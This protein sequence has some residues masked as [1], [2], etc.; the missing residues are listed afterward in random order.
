[1]K[2]QPLI[3]IGIPAYNRP[4]GL[5]RTLECL[6]RQTYRNIEIII[7]N[8]CSP[9][10]ETE[11]VAKEYIKRDSR[12]SY[13]H[14]EMNMG[15]FYNFFFVL[16][17]AKGDYFMWA[18]DDDE[19]D[20]R[21]IEEC[22][23]PL[24]NNQEYGMV[25]SKYMLYS[26]VDSKQVKIDYNKFLHSRY[27]KAH[28]L[29]LDET[30]THKANMSYGLWR[31]NVLRIVVEQAKRRGLSQKHMG[32][33]YDQAFLLIALGVTKIHQISD[34][35]F[36][37]CYNDRLI[38]GSKKQLMSTCLRN[39]KSFLRNPISYSRMVISDT[40]FYMDTIKSVYG[41]MDT[42]MP[43]IVFG[44]KRISYVFLRYIL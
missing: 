28:F 42:P 18:S 1:M 37:K 10:P 13:Y 15:G 17:K 39:I 30:L 29:L 6:N 40:K 32:R 22:L 16:E 3:S 11:E 9:V 24:L 25:F 8:D 41:K 35:L 38:P 19:W 14:Q 33:G 23:Q 34:T 36:T 4:E 2:R 43:S 44:M 20:S 26:P 31:I 7:S 27:C 21:Y 12:A 5:L